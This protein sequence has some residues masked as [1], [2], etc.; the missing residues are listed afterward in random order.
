MCS[1][2]PNIFS[3]P[4]SEEQTETQITNIKEKTFDKKVSE[5]EER[6]QLDLFSDSNKVGLATEIKITNNEDETFDRK[7]SESEEL[8]QLDLISDDSK[9]FRNNLTPP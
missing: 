5:S 4:K 3:S 1:E 8:A 7:V 9:S 2:F 6:A